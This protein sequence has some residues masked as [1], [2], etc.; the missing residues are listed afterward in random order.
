MGQ[1]KTKA[2]KKS[3]YLRVRLTEAQRHAL[4]EAATHNGITMSAWVLERMLRNLRD[5][6]I[7]V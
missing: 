3:V 4:E 1:R 7:R 5:E 2:N 6:G